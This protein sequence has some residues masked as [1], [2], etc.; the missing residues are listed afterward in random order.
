MEEVE[1]E[2]ERENKGSLNP[3]IYQWNKI[4]LLPCD[5]KSKMVPGR[6]PPALGAGDAN[7]DDKRL[8]AFIK[9]LIIANKKLFF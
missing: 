7:L 5:T 2:T 4:T 3:Q 6:R 1:M 8:Q 9:K